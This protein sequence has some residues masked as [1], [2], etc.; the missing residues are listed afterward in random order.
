ME[1]DAS[2]WFILIGSNDAH[3][4]PVFLLMMCC[5]ILHNLLLARIWKLILVQMMHHLQ[6]TKLWISIFKTLQLQA[7]PF[8]HVGIH[9]EIVAHLIGLVSAYHTKIYMCMFGLNSFERG[10]QCSSGELGTWTKACYFSAYTYILSCHQPQ[11]FSVCVYL[12]TCSVWCTLVTLMGTCYSHNR[13]L[14][15]INL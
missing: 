6:L 10:E 2:K 9:C 3:Q 11:C 13:Y 4:I 1:T 7:L 8:N 15:H 5:T 12:L 14:I